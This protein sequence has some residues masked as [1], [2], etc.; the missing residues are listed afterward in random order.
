MP[1][2]GSKRKKYPLQKYSYGIIYRMFW[3][4]IFIN[5]AKLKH[6]NTAYSE[7]ILSKILQ[8]MY[9][10]RKTMAPVVKWLPRPTL[11]IPP[12]LPNPLLFPTSLVFNGPQFISG[13]NDSED[14]VP[15]KSEREA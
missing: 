11:P 1:N 4:K 15:Q 14:L 7:L 10:I 12:I 6:N 5:K 2:L 13:W 9:S 3:I 8:F